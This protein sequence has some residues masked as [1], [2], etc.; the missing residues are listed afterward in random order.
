MSVV[1]KEL[2]LHDDVSIR[3][4][5]KDY[6]RVTDVFLVMRGVVRDTN[7]EF[8]FRLEEPYERFVNH[9]LDCKEYG[10]EVESR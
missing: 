9:V 5:V 8:K 1:T 7:K 10:D 4:V 2:V 3:V 6:Y